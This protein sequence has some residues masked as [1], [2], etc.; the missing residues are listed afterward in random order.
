MLKLLKKQNKKMSLILFKLKKK[1]HNLNTKFHQNNL[2]KNFN[3]N[4]KLNFN[5]FK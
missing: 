1:F 2:K 3:K 5:N 4:T